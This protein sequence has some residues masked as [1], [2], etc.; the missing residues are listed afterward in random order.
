MWLYRL[1]CL[2]GFHEWLEYDLH[3]DKRICLKVGCPR[4]DV[5]VGG[6]WRRGPDWG[7]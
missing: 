3:E 1:L 4:F 6:K 7:V 2:L 5:R